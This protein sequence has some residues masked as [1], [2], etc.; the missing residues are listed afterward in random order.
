MEQYTLQIRYVDSYVL[1]DLSGNY[2]C[3][4]NQAGLSDQLS[5]D[6][7]MTMSEVSSVEAENSNENPSEHPGELWIYLRRFAVHNEIVQ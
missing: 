6:L 1:V 2:N 4:E 5:V 7:S 3:V